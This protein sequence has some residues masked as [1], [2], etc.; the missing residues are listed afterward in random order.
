MNGDALPPAAEAAERYCIGCLVRFPQD[1]DELFH[2]LRPA[3]FVDER[4]RLIFTKA[5][6][7]FA[8][9]E[10]D[11]VLLG[12][13]CKEAG[14]LLELAQ[15]VATRAHVATEAKRIIEARDK[16]RLFILG[17][18]MQHD[19]LNGKPSAD[20]GCSLRA[21]LDDI[22]RERTATAEPEV[23]TSSDLNKQ[24]PSL[25]PVVIDGILRAGETCNII[26]SSKV[27]KSWLG[28]G[29]AWAVVSG[30]P[31]LGRFETTSGGVLLCD[32]ELH[33]ETLS[34]RIAKVADSMNIDRGFYGDDFVIRPMRG[35]LKSIEYV[36][37]QLEREER[38]KYRLILFD[39]KYRFLKQGQSE[40][41][42]SSETNF[43]NVIDQIADATDAAIVLIHHASKGEQGSKRTSD[44]GAGSGAQSRA[45]D[46]H[47]VLR[48]HED[49]E[50]AVLDAVLRSFA[51]VEPLAL[52]W[53]FPLW[54]PSTG[55]DPS[56][57]KG[58][59]GRQEEK[60]RER[61]REGKEKTLKALR[62]KP[63]TTRALRRLTG[64]GKDRQE[65]ILNILQSEGLVAF[66]DIVIKG[67]QSHEYYLTS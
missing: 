39:A 55:V 32:N 35:R 26:A 41:D 66:R 31:W 60:Q 64:Y 57:I 61:D 27:G 18:D 2:R 51:P 15:D 6:E 50:I 52:R 38:G 65:T 8:A 5:A 17:R 4:H 7:Q 12:R 16:R 37:E 22:E 49:P 9:G 47:L 53:Q 59:F 33:R 44:V 34:H 30:Q 56:A 28:Y 45:T 25:R 21:D 36:A 48:E 23:F 46:T 11:P 3:D 20:I 67:N 19:A 63:A 24:Y 10:I 1:T 43:Y 58:R 29:L 42:S 13:E 54:V 14:Y 62:D 40:N